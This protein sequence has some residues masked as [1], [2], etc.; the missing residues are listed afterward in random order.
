MA[1]LGS[2]GYITASIRAVGLYIFGPFI[3]P[4]RSGWLGAGSMFRTDTLTWTSKSSWV[5]LA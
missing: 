1:K 4:V 2:T 3:H 5:A